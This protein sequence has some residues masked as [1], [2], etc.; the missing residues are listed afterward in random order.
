MAKSLTDFSCNAF[1]R[2]V[3]GC[4]ITDKLCALQYLFGFFW[5]EH[6]RY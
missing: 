3:D 4:F 6:R 2:R 5:C 1:K